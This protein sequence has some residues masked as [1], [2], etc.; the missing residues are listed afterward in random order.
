MSE[1]EQEEKAQRR[2]GAEREKG[3]VGRKGGEERG[4]AGRRGMEEVT[5]EGRET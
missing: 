2:V 5:V 1:E 4:E 3:G